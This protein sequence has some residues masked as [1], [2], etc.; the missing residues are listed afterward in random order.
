MREHV[1]FW[2]SLAAA[3]FLSADSTSSGES[4]TGVTAAVVAALLV[5]VLHRTRLLAQAS[6]HR[7]PSVAAPSADERCRRGAFRRQSQADAPGRPLPRAPQL[8]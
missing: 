1:L 4:L 2:L 6:S 5:S 7:T 8:A 3:L